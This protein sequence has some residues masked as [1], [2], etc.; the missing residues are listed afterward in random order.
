MTTTFRFIPK[1]LFYALETEW[2]LTLISDL[3]LR[4]REL[5][6]ILNTEQIN[7]KPWLFQDWKPAMKNEIVGAFFP[8]DVVY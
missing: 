8:L 4:L 3:V 7:I 5:S 2:R 6:S 1:I